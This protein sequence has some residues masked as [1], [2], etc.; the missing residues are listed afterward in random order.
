MEPSKHYFTKAVCVLDTCSIINLDDIQLA[1]NDVLYYMRCFFDVRVCGTIREE[2][3]RHKDRVTSREA[4]YWNSFLSSATYNP[5]VLTDDSTVVGPFYSNIPA[6]FDGSDDA[7]ERGNAR[8]ALELLITRTAGHA[9]FVTD[10]EK[11]CNAFLQTLRR[12]F[13]GV[14][15]WNSADVI[16]HLGSVLLKEKKTSYENIRDALRDV[17]A[18][19][20]KK[21]QQINDKEKSTI[22]KNQ[23]N[24]V[25]SLRLLK[26][27]VDHWRN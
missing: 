10:D 7:G 8:V 4:S 3:Q 13:P 18:S 26:K 1:R 14:H 21:W 6:S 11:A 25:N 2:L 5:I 17:Y 22:I 12:S 27:V 20:A 24:S 23:N 16:L 19:S 15:I 9:I